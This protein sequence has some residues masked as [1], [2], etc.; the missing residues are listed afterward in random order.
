MTDHT[1]TGHGIHGKTEAI[2][3]PRNVLLI[4][5]VETQSLVWDSIQESEGKQQGCIKNK[6]LN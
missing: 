4:L 6:T 2:L 3:N 5:K 1:W